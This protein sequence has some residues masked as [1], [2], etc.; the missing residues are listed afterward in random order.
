VR[1]APG[2]DDRL[3]SG[4]HHLFHGLGLRPFRTLDDLE[5]D[6]VTFVQALVARLDNRRIMD[7]DIRT[8]VLRDESEPFV[9][10]KLL[11]ASVRHVM[12]LLA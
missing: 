7:E 3:S 9:G 12:I 10:V 8:I 11:H 6:L 1:E 4:G 2:R 5:F